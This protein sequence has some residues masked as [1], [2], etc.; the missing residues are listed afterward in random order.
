[1]GM[2]VQMS[3]ALWADLVSKTFNKCVQWYQV[4]GPGSINYNQEVI[5]PISRGEITPGKPIYFRPFR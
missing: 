1:M 3:L 4:I 2:F 5:T